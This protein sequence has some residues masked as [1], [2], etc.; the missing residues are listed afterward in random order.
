MSDSRDQVLIPLKS[1]SKEFHIK[2][3]NWRNFARFGM[4]LEDLDTFA[5]LFLIF[6]NCNLVVK[7]YFIG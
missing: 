4:L 3:L 5:G 2:Y 1:S 7:V 6:I